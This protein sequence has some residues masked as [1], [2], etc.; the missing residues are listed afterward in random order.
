MKFLSSTIVSEYKIDFK[1]N[2]TGISAVETIDI[3]YCPNYSAPA[4]LEITTEQLTWEILEFM[5]G[6]QYV[7]DL[8]KDIFERYEDLQ[9][10]IKET[11]RKERI[12]K[13]TQKYYN[14][15]TTQIINS[16]AVKDVL[17]ENPDVTIKVQDLE[18]FLT[19][20]SVNPSVK[21]SYKGHTT[22]MSYDLESR[23]VIDYCDFSNRTRRYKKISSLVEKWTELVDENMRMK[24]EKE[25]REMDSKTLHESRLAILND[26]FAG[27]DYVVTT[28]TYYD[29]HVSSVQYR[30]NIN[31]HKVRFEYKK[32][33]IQ[34]F[35]SFVVKDIQMIRQ[36]L[37]IVK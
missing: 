22:W 36:I 4:N 24:K 32:T 21:L 14:S 10:E 15:R 31:G 20:H 29:S 28:S 19:C 35:A 9:A 2:V 17:K 11:A 5:F 18:K 7:F 26:N 12:E 13:R 33:A 27:D 25:M 16:A 3:T 8:K 23:F 30:Y 6:E 34:F 37:D 1:Y